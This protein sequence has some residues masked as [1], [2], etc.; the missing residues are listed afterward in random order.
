MSRVTGNLRNPMK[1]AL[2]L[3]SA[4]SGT[5]HF[6]RQRATAI[7]VLLLGLYTLGL[8][9]FCLTRDFGTAVAIVKHPV[10]M[11]VLIGLIIAMFWHGKLGLQMV[12]EDYVHTPLTSLILQWIITFVCAIAAIAGVT[13]IIRIALGA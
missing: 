11:V 3:G 4:K 8:V 6:V 13:A 5:G 10:N 2:G 12:V 7:G 9:L 1:T